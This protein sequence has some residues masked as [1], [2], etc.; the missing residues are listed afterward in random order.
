MRVPLPWKG[1]EVWPPYDVGY[2]SED[3]DGRIQISKVP[4][5]VLRYS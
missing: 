3:S 4:F 5:M 1:L 2:I